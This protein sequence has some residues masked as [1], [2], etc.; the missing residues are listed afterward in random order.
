MTLNLYRNTS[1]PKTLNKTI[2]E[3]LAVVNDVFLKAPTN[4]LNPVFVLTDINVKPNYLYC[5]ELER[6]YFIEGFGYM[7]GERVEYRCR[8]DVLMTYVDSIKELYGVVN[9]A[10]AG[11]NVLIDDGFKLPLA[12][13]DTVNKKL[14]GGELSNQQTADSKCL[15]LQVYGGI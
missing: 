6:Y 3:P 15:V 12:V 8:V 13:T 2:G 1:D 14:Y 10:G 5:P 11:Y 4:L 9:R 7:T